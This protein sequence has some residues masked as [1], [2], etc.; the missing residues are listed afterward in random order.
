MTPPSEPGW[1]VGPAGTARVR[2]LRSGR[3]SYADGLALQERLV[4][5]RR[6]GEAP[7]TL[8]LL[9]HDPVV[10]LG[11]G[12]DAGHLLLDPG[13]LAARGIDFFETGRG[14]DVTIHSPGQVVG[15]PILALLGAQR[16]AHLYLR[17]LE[18]VMILAAH[19][20]GVDAGRAAGMTGIWVGRAKLGAIGVRLNSGWITSHGFAFNVANDLSLFDVIVP[21]GIR[22]RDVTSLS[23]LLGREVSVADAM[24]R[25]ETR[26]RERFAPRE[27]PLPSNRAANEQFGIRSREGVRA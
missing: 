9:E 8:V 23:R 11:R 1:S 3:I 5:E 17:E 15:Y 6:R 26:F 18:E 25:L 13:R 14:G 19:D 16:D 27:R 20:L 4:G 22:G 7:D 2:V 12:G 10:T 24:D 21:C